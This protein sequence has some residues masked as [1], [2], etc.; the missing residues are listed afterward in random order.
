MDIKLLKQQVEQV[1]GTSL[2]ISK[3][4]LEDWHSQI[5][6]WGSTDTG[7]LRANGRL[8]WLA[9]MQGSSVTVLEAEAAQ[10]TDTESGLVQMLLSIA[11]GGASSPLTSPKRDDE[12]RSIQL[13]EWLQ[14]RLD[15]NDFN[16]QVPGHMPIKAKLKG[17]LLPFLLSWDNQGQ[18][19]AI[20]FT[21]LNKL[22]RSYF[23][24]E[25]ILVPLK[26]EWLI[27]LGE[28]LLTSLREESEE[29]AETERDMLG[30]LCQGLYELITNEWVGGFH[31]AVGNALIGDAELTSAT[32][33]L[34]QTLSLGRIFNV[35][36]QIHLPWELRLERLIYS[37][38]EPQRRMFTEETGNHA[39]LLQDEETLTTLETFFA[40]D[41]NVSETAKRLYIHRNTLLYR[42]E[43]FKQET[44]LD[45]RTFRDAVLVKLELLLYKVTKR[46]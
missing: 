16:Q 12:A 23:G 32:Q 6:Q 37:I 1:I 38:P 22:L 27:L 33:S 9:D 43:K 2:T 34:R 24:G 8:I 20:S 35:T 28:E 15:L 30:A 46:P 42:I 19:Q 7:P 3:W 39:R 31:L 29:A 40:L 11:R 25:V 14:E 41:C 13:G 45:V 5:A 10:V 26:E 17:R 18:G 36:N 4:E 21:K 44:G